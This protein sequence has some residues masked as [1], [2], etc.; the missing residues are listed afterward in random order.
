[1][2]ERLW[3]PQLDVYDSVRRIGLLLS[4]WGGGA[5]ALERLYIADFYLA[6]P[7]LLNNSSMPGT[8]RAEFRKLSVPKP[9]NIFLSYPAAPLLFHKMEPIQIQAIQAL[10]GKGVIDAE[11]IKKGRA[12]L[13]QLGISFVDEHLSD[14]VTNA[15]QKIIVFLTEHFANVGKENTKELRHR[16]GLRRMI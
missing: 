12:G 5:P 11:A 9:E 14:G 1:M 3:Y 15:E 8:V 16:T 10:I 6:N 4:A 13:S 7:P 2:M